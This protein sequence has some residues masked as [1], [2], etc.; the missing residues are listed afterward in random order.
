VNLWNEHWYV[1]YAVTLAL[2][3]NG[4]NGHTGPDGETGGDE[5]IVE[6]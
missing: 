6:V 1:V 4:H 3:L 5:R 2:V